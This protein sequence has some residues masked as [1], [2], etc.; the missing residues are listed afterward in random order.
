MKTK[1][2]TVFIG[3]GTGRCGTTS[4]AKLIAG[5]KDAVCHH[6]RRPLLPWVFL[7]ELF[8]E[9][10]KW[11]SMSTAGITGD[12][13]FFY[14]PYLEKLIGVF[15]RLKIVCLERNRQAVIDSFLWKT[16]WQNRWVNHDGTEWVKDTVWDKTFPKYAI[17]DK[18]RAIGAYWDEY[19]KKI[20][21]V[22][23]KYP[24]SVKRMTTEE[25][26]TT[27]GQQKIFDFLAIPEKSRR[28]IKQPRYNARESAARPWSK[29]E[30]FRWFQKR[31]LTSKDIAAVIPPETDF[32]LVDDQQVHDYLPDRY[33]AL[34]FLERNG[35]Y[36]G[37][38]PD[39]AT[40]ICEL[41][42]LRQSGAQFIV[43]AWTAFWHLG[44][45]TGLNAHLRSHYRCLIENDRIACFDLRSA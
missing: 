24:A 2:K 14:L 37:P 32:I 44:Y 11:F 39:D 31:T 10:V 12:V 41:D 4:L 27:R 20:R 13:A 6:E 28:Y 33:C 22:A 35:V 3:C 21:R 29:E 38:P 1:D 23:G 34:P 40:A 42:R 7:E 43:F 9:R 15:P 18:A 26:N 25:L 45:Y 19:R 16:Q 8:Q 36:W 30:A 17:A 5:C